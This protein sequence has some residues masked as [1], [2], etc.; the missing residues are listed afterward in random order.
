MRRNNVLAGLSLTV[1]LLQGALVY[2]SDAK[3]DV[4]V[5]VNTKNPYP[6]DGDSRE[7]VKD[8]FL[9]KRDKFPDGTKA[10]PF[11]QKQGPVRQEFYVKLTGK[12]E[13]ALN[14]YWS[15]LIFRKWAAAQSR[16]RRQ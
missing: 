15:N 14:V 8:L 2:A 9:G 10:K 13:S 6:W 16:R 11:D 12:D 3:A 7:Q 1:G 4:A 5:I